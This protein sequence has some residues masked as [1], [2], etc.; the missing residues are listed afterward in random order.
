MYIESPKTSL[1]LFKVDISKQKDITLLR[2]QVN[3]SNRHRFPTR[4]SSTH[5]HYFYPSLCH[6]KDGSS[7][8]VVYAFQGL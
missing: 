7:A 1:K 4:D 2:E 3:K 6:L 8:A 5:K